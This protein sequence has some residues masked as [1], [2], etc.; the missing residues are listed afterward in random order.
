MKEPRHEGLVS[1]TRLPGIL[2][3]TAEG[4]QDITLLTEEISNLEEFLPKPGWERPQNGEFGRAW[5]CLALGRSE[6]KINFIALRAVG[7]VQAGGV[8]PQVCSSGAS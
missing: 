4:T 8:S 6:A 5:G 3:L 2:F 1:L 7:S